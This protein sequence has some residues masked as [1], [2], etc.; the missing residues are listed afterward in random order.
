MS[1]F[2]LVRPFVVSHVAGPRSQHN[3]KQGLTIISR[4]MNHTWTCR[5]N[6]AVSTLN[7][8]LCMSFEIWLIGVVLSTQTR[9]RQ[10]YHNATKRSSCS[11]LLAQRDNRHLLDLL[12][13]AQTE[14]VTT[15]FAFATNSN[16]ILWYPPGPRQNA[17]RWTRPPG[18]RIPDDFPPCS[19]LKHGICKADCSLHAPQK[20][21]N[22]NAE[23][24]ISQQVRADGPRRNTWQHMRYPNRYHLWA[25]LKTRAG[26][27]DSCARGRETLEKGVDVPVAY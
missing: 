25:G 4:C 14:N 26:L 7:E 5:A 27:I 20:T 15:P 22:T 18:S 21:T 10:W 8:S 12:T 23:N 24:Y 11:R 3:W 16:T 13:C 9:F 2:I 19:L 17:H 6:L 1:H